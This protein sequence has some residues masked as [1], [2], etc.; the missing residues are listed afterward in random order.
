MK[1]QISLFSILLLM[2]AL[3]MA[4]PKEVVDAYNLNQA[5]IKKEAEDVQK[6]VDEGYDVNFQYNGRSAL[7]TACDKNLL[8]ISKMLI[9]GGADVNSLSEGGEGRTPLQF[10]SGDIME[11]LPEL[12]ALLLEKGANPNLSLNPDQLPLFEAI[13][14]AHTETVK[15]LLEHGAEIDL[16]NSM[17]QTPLEYVSYLMERG[18]SNEETLANWHTI[19]QLLNKI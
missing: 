5:I 18:V 8:E 12:T 17:G 13:T 9:E 19:K 7:H 6:M 16:K 10:V 1:K 14:G 3:L 4:Q 11:D 15:V 2:P